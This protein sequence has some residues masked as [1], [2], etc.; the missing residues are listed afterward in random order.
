MPPGTEEVVKAAS[1]DGWPA[2]LLV[3]LIVSGFSLFGIFLRQLWLDHRDL[4]KFVRER[5]IGSLDRNSD[6]LGSIIG[7]LK[8]RPCLMRDVH[9]LDRLEDDSKD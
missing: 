7:M 1:A 4:N 2:M 8:T 5:L 3:I 6:V 9:H